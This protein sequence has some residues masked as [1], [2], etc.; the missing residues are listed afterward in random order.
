MD[1]HNWARIATLPIALLLVAALTSCGGESPASAQNKR[2]SDQGPCDLVAVAE[3]E[4]M[5]GPVDKDPG[6]EQEGAQCF[7]TFEKDS[8]AISRGADG[9]RSGEPFE[10]DGVT[11]MRYEK[12]NVCA[13]DVWLVPNDINQQFGVIAGKSDG[14][15]PCEVAVDVARLILENLSE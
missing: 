7:Y 1:R 10:I 5:F 2:L 15:G 11:A 3:L 13:V 6:P 14:Q 9:A 8:P 4:K 12:N